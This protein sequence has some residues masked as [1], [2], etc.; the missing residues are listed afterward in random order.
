MTDRFDFEQQIMNCW[1]ITN[2]IDV[3]YKR[4]KEHKLNDDEVM[5]Y[6]LGLKTIYDTKFDQLFDTFEYLIKQGNIR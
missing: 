6:L 4:L 5:N 2:D 1:N 3:L